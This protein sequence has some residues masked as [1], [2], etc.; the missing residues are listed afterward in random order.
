MMVDGGLGFWLG[1]GCVGFRLYVLTGLGFGLFGM[2][3]HVLMDDV[4]IVLDSLWFGWLGFW[5]FCSVMLGA[6]CPSL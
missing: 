3:V 1:L 6:G 2:S 5:V 4:W